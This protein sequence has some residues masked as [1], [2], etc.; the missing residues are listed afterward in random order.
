MTFLV[1]FKRLYFCRTNN[2]KMLFPGDFYKSGVTIG[3]GVSKLSELVKNCLVV[4]PPQRSI[5]SIRLDGVVGGGFGAGGAGDGVAQDAA[6]AGHGV[7]VDVVSQLDV[8]VEHDPHPL[9]GA[10]KVLAFVEQV[11]LEPFV[12]VAVRV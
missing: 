1:G 6:G 7:N 5:I 4:S 11:P 10:V 3:V 8:G 12:T 9:V 2:L